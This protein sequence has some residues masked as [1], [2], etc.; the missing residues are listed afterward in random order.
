M[1][2]YVLHRSPSARLEYRWFDPDGKAAERAIVLLHEGLG[3]V[4][5]WRDF[6]NQLALATKRP[7][8]AYSRRGYGRSD[9]V[10]KPHTTSYMHEEAL[11][12]L[13]ALL[14]D[15][16]IS[17]P[18]L[19]GHSDGA[20]IALL[21]AAS[22]IRPVGAVIVE[23]PHLFV[24]DISIRSIR[25]ARVAYESGDLRTKLARY[26][27]DVDGAF[28]GWNDIW[29]SAEFRSWNIEG[30]LKS[31]HAPLLAIQGDE[32]EYG[33]IQQID[34]IARVCPDVELLMLAD[35]RHSPH[36]DQQEQVLR[37]VQRFL[38]QLKRVDEMEVAPSSKTSQAPTCP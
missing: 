26:H 31:L 25:A 5:M 28:Y 29:L 16:N 30:D 7:V 10:G 34:R 15:L 24:E 13:P 22:G 33:T 32:D 14:D 23:A 6:P 36:R 35:C 38:R 21:H 4:S 18:I 11:E 37:A 3:S 8:L 19:F 1:S 2:A 9:P 17:S 20:S 12:Q 27:A